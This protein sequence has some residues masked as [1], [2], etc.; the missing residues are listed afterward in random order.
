[1][2]VILSDLL[3]KSHTARGLSQAG[4]VTWVVIGLTVVLPMIV[5]VLTHSK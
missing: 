1:M 5:V 4:C 3:H 2:P